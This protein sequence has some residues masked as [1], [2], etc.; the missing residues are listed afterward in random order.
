[1]HRKSRQREAILRVLRAAACHPTAEWIYEQA[2]REIPNLSLG[3]VYRNLR[4]LKQ[5]GTILELDLAGAASR[6][7]SNTEPHYHLEC[8]ECG[9]IFDI[10]ESVDESI[11]DRVSGETG[12]KVNHHYLRFRGLC[13]DCQRANE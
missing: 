9:G 13:Q 6:F 5:A 11:D 10:G 2:R 4:L 3:T 8:E 12:Y 1:M 7:D